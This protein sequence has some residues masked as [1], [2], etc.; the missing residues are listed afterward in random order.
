MSIDKVYVTR[1]TVPIHARAKRATRCF[2]CDGI[3]TRVPIHAR[4]KRATIARTSSLLGLRRSN[5]RPRE[6]GDKPRPSLARPL[7]VLFQFTPARSGRPGRHLVPYY[8]DEF[9]FT[10]ARSGRPDRAARGA[11]GRRF[12]FTPAR[13]GRPSPAT[14]KRIAAAVF[15]F[16]PARSGRLHPYGAPGPGASSNSRPREAGDTAWPRRRPT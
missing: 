4:A 8:G 6:A 9:Q 5:S 12:Q 7:L 2:L 3:S 10:P 16:T 1:N 11:Q 15:Q 14:V 13:S